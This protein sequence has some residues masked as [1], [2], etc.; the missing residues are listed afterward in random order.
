MRL[1]VS[2]WRQDVLPGLDE[3]QAMSPAA[4]ITGSPPNGAGVG[5]GADPGVAVDVG[6]GVAG[7]GV[8]V[9]VGPGVVGGGAATLVEPRSKAPLSTTAIPSP[10][11]S[12]GTWPPSKS[13][14]S[15]TLTP[16]S[17]AGLA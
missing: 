9:A 4:A 12:L 3:G 8:A 6:R 1:A 10:L 13:A 15:S 2:C 7:A 14:V 11:P 16:V 17:T 5:V